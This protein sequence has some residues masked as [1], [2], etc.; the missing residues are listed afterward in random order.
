M[1][2]TVMSRCIQHIGS[3][4]FGDFATDSIEYCADSIGLVLCFSGVAV[5]HYNVFDDMYK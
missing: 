5:T 4:L 2:D 3:S 1:A